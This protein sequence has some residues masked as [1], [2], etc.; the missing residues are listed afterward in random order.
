M[1][2]RLPSTLGFARGG[3]LWMWLLSGGIL[4]IFSLASL[5]FLY[6]DSVF[7][8]SGRGGALPGEC[9]YFLRTSLARLGITAHLWC[10]LPASVLAGVQFVPAVRRPP[11]LRLHRAIG[12]T[13]IALA[14]VG[15]LLTL[16]IIR[17]TFGGDLAS[18][19]ATTLL[20]LLFVVAQV[21]GYVKIRRKDVVRHRQWMLRSWFYVRLRQLRPLPRFDLLHIGDFTAGSII[22]M[23]IIMTS[24]AI[25]ISWIGGY[26]LAMPCDKIH[27]II[28]ARRETLQAYPDCSPYFTEGDV[29]RKAIVDADIFGTNRAQFAAA[30][31]LTYGM[32]AWLAVSSHVAGVELYIQSLKKSVTPDH[33]KKSR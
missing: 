21:A 9:F 11:L 28:G 5:R 19:S 1:A 18:Q 3:H 7:C 15:S 6:F 29:A 12:Y 13:S 26:Y 17:H 4:I 33:S 32:G 25:A 27:S 2:G 14:L 30:F 20:L 31:N 8:A 10:I 22:T 24:A 16:P 23:R